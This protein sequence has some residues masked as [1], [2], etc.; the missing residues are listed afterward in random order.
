MSYLWVVGDFV[1]DWLGRSRF[2]VLLLFGAAAELVVRIGL[3]PSPSGLAS[4]GIS[5]AVAALIGGL[6]VILMKL[7][8]KE[9]RA[10]A[11]ASL[12]RRLPVTLGLLAWFPVQLLNRYFAIAATT[13]TRE[14]VSWLALFAA[15]VLGM[16]LLSLTGRRIA[17]T[18]AEATAFPKEE[19]TPAPA[20]GA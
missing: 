2:L 19:A 5:G 11:L 8:E 4:V 1:E 18:P 14:P 9:E 10:G 7:G 16:F 3:S 15:F 6:L 13:Q 12:L 20:L 17:P